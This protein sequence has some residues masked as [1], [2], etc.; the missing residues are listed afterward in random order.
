MREDPRRTWGFCPLCGGTVA[1]IVEC[2]PSHHAASIRRLLLLL[3][4]RLGTLKA[5]TRQLAAKD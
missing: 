1:T 3:V 2:A 5:I 4:E